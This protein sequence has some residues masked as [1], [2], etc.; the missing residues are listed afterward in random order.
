ML[1]LV[2]FSLYRTGTTDINATVVKFP[3]IRY[4]LTRSGC[5]HRK[6]LRRADVIINMMIIPPAHATDK[7]TPFGDEFSTIRPS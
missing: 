1:G 7:Q 6:Y 4:G 2:C 5:I 3:G